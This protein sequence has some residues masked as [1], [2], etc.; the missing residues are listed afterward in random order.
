MFTAA[1]FLFAAGTA[2]EA[3]PVSNVEPDPK[4]MSRSEICAYNAVLDTTHPNYIRCVRSADIGSLVQRNVSC[5]T[6]RQ[7]ELANRIG[8]QNAREAYETWIGKAVN[9]S[10]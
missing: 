2:V 4:A 7:W 1:L 10:N 5:R 3:V 9:T 6:N 8:N